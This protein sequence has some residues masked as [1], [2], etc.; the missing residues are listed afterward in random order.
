ME[1]IEYFFTYGIF[2]DR[3]TRIRYGLPEQADYTTVRG[4]YT[5]GT[6]IATA[7]Q[8]LTNMCLTGMLVEIPE[9]YD[10]TTLDMIE[11]GYNR[12]VIETTTMQLV[13]DKRTPIKAYMY[14]GKE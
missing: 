14:V 11:G 2:M 12:I 7:Y 4:Y 3:R 5:L 6:S 13:D 10:W 8:G 1:Q 9:G